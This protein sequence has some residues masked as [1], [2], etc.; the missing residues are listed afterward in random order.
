MKF[1]LEIWGINYEKIRDTC[2][3][4]E[5]NGYDGF[6]YGESLA[7]IDL[8]C[9]TI[10][11]S[12]INIT[13]KIK[14]GPVITYLFPE[15]RSIALLAKQSITFQTLSNG[16]LQFRTGAGATLQ[17]SVQWWY[18]YGIEYLKAINRVE[19]LNEGLYVLDRLWNKELS[20]VR[21]KGTYFEL[22]D[23]NIKIPQIL[24]KKIPITVAAKKKK[25][26]TIAAK[27][28]DIW[29]SSYLS[30]KE[31][32]KLNNEFIHITD[33]NSDRK[34]E[35]S[36]ELDVVIAQSI[37][38]LEYKQKLFAMERGPNVLHQIQKHGLI[39]NTT[40]V[41][42]KIKEYLEAGVTQFLLA[43][44][45]PFDTSSIELFNDVIKAVK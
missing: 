19:L 30:P 25:T 10:L 21:F 33:K 28:A 40:T 11:S 4:A 12:L 18:P 27:Y 14:L 37:T 1:C 23:A 24:T 7:N 31:F 35:R 26:M 5:K 17:Y 15:Y 43:F 42:E 34:I 38:D 36:I 29:E 6:F 13:N 16:R 44:Q 45:D 9:W 32:L 41:A 2:I 8:D 22:N 20:S 3:F 39:G